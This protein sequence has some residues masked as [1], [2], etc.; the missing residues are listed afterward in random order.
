MSQPNI[1]RLQI[2]MTREM[3]TR[4]DTDLLQLQNCLDRDCDDTPQ[5]VVDDCFAEIAGSCE[6]LSSITQSFVD[7]FPRKDRR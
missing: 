6:I 1:T 5:D 4:I 3:L 7:F 2:K